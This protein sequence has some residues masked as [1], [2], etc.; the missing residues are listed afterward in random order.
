MMLLKDRLS[1]TH[2]ELRTSLNFQKKMAET[3][4]TTI[5]C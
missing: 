1:R 2:L 5:S 3:V 4:A